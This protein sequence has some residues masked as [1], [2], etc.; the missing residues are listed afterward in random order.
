MPSTQRYGEDNQNQ[1]YLTDDHGYSVDTGEMRA[2]F[3][4]YLPVEP[5]INL[6]RNT[7]KAGLMNY[8]SNAKPKFVDHHAES[9]PSLKLAVGR[10]PITG[11]IAA[12]L[13]NEMPAVDLSPEN[14]LL[15]DQKNKDPF[16]TET[17]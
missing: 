7:K 8:A 5:N 12:I 10:N 4:S 11:N 9:N 2:D 3:K 1:N 15:R 14:K 13:P 17:T 6:N 16:D